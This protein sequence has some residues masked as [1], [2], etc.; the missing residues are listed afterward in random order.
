MMSPTQ[1]EGDINKP[2]DDLDNSGSGLTLVNPFLCKYCLN[3][4]SFSGENPWT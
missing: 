4:V 1:G 2:M 3:A